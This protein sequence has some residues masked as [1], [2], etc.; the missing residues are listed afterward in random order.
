MN[1]ITRKS[2]VIKTYMLLLIELLIVAL[3]FAAAVLLRF[4]NFYADGNGD[5]HLMFGLFLLAM[6]LMYSML[7]DWN[8]DFFVRGF[9]REF[10]AI[11]KYDITITVL[12]II[13]MY[14]RKDVE[15][16]SRLVFGVFAVVNQ[17][18]TYLAHIAF[19][20]YMFRHYKKSVNSDKLM[21]I[22][23]AAR[24]NEIVAQIQAEHAWEY[25]LTCIAIMDEK[26][27]GEKILD[28]PVVADSDD[29]MDVATQSILDRVFI[30][31]PREQIDRARDL[32]MDFEAMGVLCH[33]DIDLEELDMEGREAGS[34]AGFSVLSFSLQNMD[35][36]RLLIKRFFDILGSLVGLLFTLILFP[37]IAIAIKLDSKGP[38][39]FKQ[40]RIGKNGRRFILYKFRSM[41]ADAE[42]K[43]EELMEKNEVTGLMFKMED[44]PRITKVGRFLRKTSLDEFPQFW[45]VLK[46]DMSLVGTRPPTV[47][48][49]QKYNVHYRRRLSITPG[50]TGLWQVSGRSDIKDFDEVVR[51]DLEYIDR[52]SLALDMRLLLQTIG[53]VLFGKGSK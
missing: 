24:V 37:F 30:S 6:S 53:V 15:L 40:E 51:L 20:E 36:R 41:R 46:G 10:F 1:T 38:V 3:S 9:Y 35:Y 18:L 45:N 21:V 23:T 22:T 31:L 25:E 19:K 27:T 52:W 29:L 26:R 5:T 39:I 34:F 14:M 47:E 4:R 13:F 8:R 42:A 49:F 28:I 43:K 32:I 44:D 12:S 16:L 50:L 17:I 7:T 48:E 33:Y 2:R 11:L